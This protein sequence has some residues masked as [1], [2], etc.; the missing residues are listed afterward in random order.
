MKAGKDASDPLKKAGESLS[1]A[2]K[3]SGAELKRAYD[4]R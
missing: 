4:H 1:T 3:W 2:A